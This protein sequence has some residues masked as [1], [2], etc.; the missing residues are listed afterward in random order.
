[1][2]QMLAGALQTQG[3]TIRIHGSLS[4][5]AIG[6]GEGINSLALLAPSDQSDDVIAELQEMLAE[7]GGEAG[8]LSLFEGEGGELAFEEGAGE[9]AVSQVDP[10]LPVAPLSREDDEPNSGKL[11]GGLVIGVLLAIGAWLVGGSL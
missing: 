6:A 10:D 11:A 2:I 8:L 7:A 5:A 3:F 9:G 4:G 1:M